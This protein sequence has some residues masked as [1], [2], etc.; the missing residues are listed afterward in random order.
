MCNNNQ[1]GGKLYCPI[2][3]K[4]FLPITLQNWKKHFNSWWA[5]KFHALAND[6]II[7]S[8]CIVKVSI[9]EHWNTFEQVSLPF[10]GSGK[11]FKCIEAWIIIPDRL[12]SIEWNFVMCR[13][14]KSIFIFFEKTLLHAIPNWLVWP[15]YSL[16]FLSPIRGVLKTGWSVWKRVQA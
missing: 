1:K 14:P 7:F 16:Y 6:R 5:Y 12:R 15:E 10:R 13:Y 11:N 8:C 4:S 9:T 3:E 2:P